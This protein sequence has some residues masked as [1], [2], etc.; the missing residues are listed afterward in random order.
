[1][2]I[3]LFP[4]EIFAAFPFSLTIEGQYIIKNLVVLSA[5]I[6]LGATVRGGRLDLDVETNT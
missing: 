6:V 1:M 3:F 5:G 2:P 4:S